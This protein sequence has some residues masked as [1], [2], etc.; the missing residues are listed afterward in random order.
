VFSL[1][2][3]SPLATL[4]DVYTPFNVQFAGIYPTIVFILVSMQR[5]LDTTLGTSAGGGTS[6][7]F[8][9]RSAVRSGARTS[10]TPSSRRVRLELPNLNTYKPRA[11]LEDMP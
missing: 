1:I 10:A 9:H 6:L 5:G 3:V 11:D 8:R 4:G 7:Q 2:R